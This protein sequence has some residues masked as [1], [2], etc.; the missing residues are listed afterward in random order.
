M[1]NPG[2]TTGGWCS[3]VARPPTGGSYEEAFFA[4]TGWPEAHVLAD[5]LLCRALRLLG[6][7]AL[8]QEYAKVERWFE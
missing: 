3:V 7:T 8:V 1:D 5:D 4:H 2:G 6:A